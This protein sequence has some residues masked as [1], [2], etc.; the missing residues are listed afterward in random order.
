MQRARIVLLAFTAVAACGAKKKAQ[1]AQ[2]TDAAAPVAV[3]EP[4]AKVDVDVRCERILSHELLTKHFR[5]RH[6]E[7]GNDAP[8]W[9]RS[10]AIGP[11]AG[12]PGEVG[13]TIQVSCGK[14]YVTEESL[15]PQREAATKQGFQ[16]LDGIGRFAARRQ[17]ELRL[18]DDDTPCFFSVH[19][20]TPPEKLVDFA[21]DLAAATTPASYHE[22]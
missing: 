5:G 8:A 14:A 17:G 7:P 10:C 15:G 18:F 9:S 3:A 1:P 22:P 21:R 19:G 16:P 12:K 20:F 13:T 4:A 11:P 2:A 6:L